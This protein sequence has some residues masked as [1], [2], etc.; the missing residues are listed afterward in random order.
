MLK[1]VFILLVIGIIT[2]TSAS[3]LKIEKKEEIVKSFQIENPIKIGK[4][5]LI[6][7]ENPIGKIIIPSI[8]LEKPLYKIDSKK[9]NIDENVTI[10]E[11]SKSPSIENG[12]LYIA[13]H[14]GTA[15]NAYFNDLD[16]VKL[17][18]EVIVEYE[19][20]EYRYL[21]KDIKEQVKNGYI[22]G[23]REKKKQL[24]LTTC[25]PHKNNCQLILSCIEKGS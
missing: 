24:I 14:S 16:Q 3:L 8:Q 4:I 25:C 1:K 10:L 23:K 13:A 19:G 18:D 21:V 17:E 6:K 11:G 5:N 2:I 15:K 7:V 12:I 20:I 22:E 9:N